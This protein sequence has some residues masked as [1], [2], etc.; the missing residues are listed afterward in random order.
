MPIESS[1]RERP[2]SAKAWLRELRVMSEK[3]WYWSSTLSTKGAEA[4]EKH[5]DQ[6]GVLML[7]KR[8]VYSS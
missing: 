6:I 8:H 2:E 3:G 4:V 7:F 5:Q 1:S